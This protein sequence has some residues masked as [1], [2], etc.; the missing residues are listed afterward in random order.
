MGKIYEVT[1]V[2]GKYKDKSGTEKSR[3]MNIGS[4]IDTK[5]GPMLKL[6]GVPI[7]WDGWAYLNEPKARP[8][9]TKQAEG[10]DGGEIPF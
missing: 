10:E 5:N 3:Y 2:T 8:E 1:A 7:G 9:G 6:E 4:V